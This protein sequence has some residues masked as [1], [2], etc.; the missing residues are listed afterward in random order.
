LKD[1]GISLQGGL[2]LTRRIGDLLVESGVVTEAQVAEVL[3][4]KRGDTERLGEAMVRLGFLT[5]GQ[6]AEV[7][8]EQLGL[9]LVSLTQTA[10]NSD[11]LR[12]LPEEMIRR[13]RIL[14]IRLESGRLLLG[15]SDPLDY[16]ALEDARLA[17][18]LAIDPAV[19]VRSEL[20]TFIERYFGMKQSLNDS[21]QAVGR[22]SSGRVHQ[23]EASPVGRLLIQLLTHAVRARAS[24]VHFDPGEET[25][26]VR[27]R[28][29]GVLHDEEN[30][31][32]NV[33]ANLL[34]RVKI[35]SELDITEH[36][37]PQDGRIRVMIDQHPIDLRVAILPVMRGEKVVL[38]ILDA[39]SQ[40]QTLSG[41][42]F[43][44]D[45]LVR[46][47][48]ALSSNGGLILAVGPTGS[49]KT[50]TLYAV[51]QQVSSPAINT[52]TIEDPVE[53]EISG[54]SQV[55]VNVN[56][57]LTF[58][59]GLRSILRQDPDVVMVGEIRDEETA[60]IASRAALTGH[61]VLS[62]LHTLGAMETIGRLRE[63]GLA[64]YLLASAI[65]GVVAQRL[66][67]RICRGCA[68]PRLIAASERAWIHEAY[69]R[70]CEDAGS[71]ADNIQWPFAN[72]EGE[73]VLEGKGCP[74]C[75][76][77][78]LRGRVAIHEVIYWDEDLRAG[79]LEEASESE[80]RQRARRQ[81]AWSLVYDGLVKVRRGETT[82]AEVIRSTGGQ[83]I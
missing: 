70:E 18:G 15:M 37:L 3:A 19:V 22:Q 7:L 36:R 46:M 72:Q 57:G 83:L 13:H 11:V 17:S 48:R 82:I 40:L 59:A 39:R 12:L 51:L 78:G 30:L 52:V 21:L 76:G 24:D 53:F 28:V 77:T 9:P 71:Y 74:D 45:N 25:V 67:R 55:A 80:L 2:V 26:R 68:R 69:R 31:P 1:R 5:D 33:Y 61:L 50:T 66:L 43:M 54:I 62:T 29:D 16:Y 14:P 60:E 56:T 44:P 8:H 42:G 75:G 6:L 38:R 4:A 49:G 27:F 32:M 23:E 73:T 35:L 81:G 65:R 47:E 41:L 20:E 64:P 79:V 10:A 63:M 34:S 58:S